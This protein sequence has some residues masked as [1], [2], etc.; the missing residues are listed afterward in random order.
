MSHPFEKSKDSKPI[1]RMSLRKNEPAARMI[2]GSRLCALHL[3]HLLTVIFAKSTLTSVLL[4]ESGLDIG[5]KQFCPILQ[6]NII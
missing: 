5:S 4:T 3:A 1:E 2:E 6:Q